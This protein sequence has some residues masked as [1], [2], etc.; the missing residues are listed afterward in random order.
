MVYVL[1]WNSALSAAGGSYGAR[2][3]RTGP[4]LAAVVPGDDE[5]AVGLDG[6]RWRRSL[7]VVR[8]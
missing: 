6:H 7:P 3:R 4:V 5:V 8:S 2:R 1:T